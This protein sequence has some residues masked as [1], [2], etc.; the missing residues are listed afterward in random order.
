MGV[1][2]LW[3]IMMSLRLKLCV[4]FFF[5]FQMCDTV[6]KIIQRPFF[7]HQSH[8]NPTST[9]EVMV[10]QVFS[11]QIGY[12]SD[13]K[14]RK[15]TETVQSNREPPLSTCNRH[16]AYGW[17]D[18]SNTFLLAQVPLKSDHGKRRYEGLK[19]LSSP[20]KRSKFINPIK[21]I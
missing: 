8:G 18:H 10:S 7:W 17:K 19:T 2:L 15:I 4:Q 9:S 1:G 14:I 11:W 13:Q 5:P 16:M 21:R 3:V 12:K 6:G 20:K